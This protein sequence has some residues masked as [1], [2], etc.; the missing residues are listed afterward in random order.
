MT[1]TPDLYFKSLPE[2]ERS[3]IT[4]LIF[5]INNKSRWDTPW[6]KGKI[7][8][9]QILE[10]LSENM[11]YSTDQL[12]KILIEDINQTTLNPIIWDFANKIS[13]KYRTAIA[14]I[15]TDVFSKY[16]IPALDLQTTFHQ[17]VNSSDYGVT[18]KT[19]LC[20]L[21]VQKLDE[22]LEFENCL[23]IDDSKKNIDNFIL[24]GGNGYHYKTDKEFGYWLKKQTILEYFNLPLYLVI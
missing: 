7:S 21:V 24:S 19:E 1:L 9:K 5:G 8:Y 12:E 23:L 4:E 18:N 11:D 3:L 20:R 14:T 22:P 10:Y 15:N 6:M 16:V 2:E 13:K 17:V